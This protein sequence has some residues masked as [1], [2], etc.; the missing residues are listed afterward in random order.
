[1]KGE[2]QSESRVQIQGMH[3]QLELNSRIFAKGQAYVAL[4]RVRSL[5]GDINLLSERTRLRNLPSNNP[6]NEANEP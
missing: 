6:N 3:H 2:V 4:S 1:M 5:E